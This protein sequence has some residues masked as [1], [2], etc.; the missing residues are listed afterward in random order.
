MA[1]EMQTYEFVSNCHPFRAA[2][3]P[4][5]TKSLTFL[6]ASVYYSWRSVTATVLIGYDVNIL[7]VV[8]NIGD[9]CASYLTLTSIL[10][11]WYLFVLRNNFDYD[12]K[13]MIYLMWLSAT[14]NLFSHSLYL[15]LA[16]ATRMRCKACASIEFAND[17]KSISNQVCNNVTN[18]RF[19]YVKLSI[20]RSCL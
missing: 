19:F 9:F 3:T 14:A 17:A 12:T 4:K 7:S 18:H 5:H 16:P 11:I 8:M 13:I 6:A 20:G 10:T 2:A 1:T 15:A